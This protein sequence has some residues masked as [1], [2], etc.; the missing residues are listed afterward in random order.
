MTVGGWAPLGS[1]LVPALG[2][3]HWNAAFPSA[4]IRGA[5]R[6]EKVLAIISEF[7]K[8]NI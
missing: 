1:I 7:K 6:V 8:K 5:I 3:A 2:C 4:F